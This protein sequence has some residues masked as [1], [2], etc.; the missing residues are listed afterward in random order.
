LRQWLTAFGRVFLFIAL[1]LA[2]LLGGGL[3]LQATGR[4]DS[5]LLQSVVT[6]VA[7]FVAGAILI[8]RLEHRPVGALGL[9]RTSKTLR[10]LWL[11][12]A[13]GLGAI[14]CAVAIM[15]LGGRLRYSGEPGTSGAWLAVVGSGFATLGIAALEEEVLFRGYAFQVLVQAIGGVAAT[16]LASAIFA[17]AHAPNPN[18]DAFA[19]INIFLAGILL[20]VAYLRTRSLWFATTVHLGWNWGMALLFDLPVSGLEVFDAPLYE[21]AVAGPRWFTGGAFGPEGGIVGSLAFLLALVAVLKTPGVTVAPEMRALRP[22]GLGTEVESRKSKV[23]SEAG[24]DAGT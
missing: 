6:G 4:G 9:A 13:I 2:L 12:L 11:G 21:P 5:F 16:L 1:F 19:L 7:A 17:A 24:P 10:E 20:S 18:V 3:L 23:E 22:L 14:A 8:R 15:I